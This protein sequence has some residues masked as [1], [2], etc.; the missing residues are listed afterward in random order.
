MEVDQLRYFLRV[1]ERGNFTRAAEELMISQPALSRSIQKLEEELGQ[2]VFERKTRSVALTEAG[3][4]LQS[5][6]QQVLTLLADTKA[7]IS[8]DGQSGQIRVGAIPTIA[9]FFLPDLLRQFSAEFPKA[10]LIVQEDTTDHLLKRCTQG[11][12]DLAII[13]LPIPAKYLEV[14]ELFEEELFLVL[15][16]DHPLVNKPHIRLNDIKSYPFVLLDEAHCL[17]DNIVSFCR[18]RSFHPVA[19]EQTSQLAMVQELVSLSH[20]ISMIPQMARQLDKTD[21]RVYR[22]ISGNRPTRKIAVVWNP[23]RFQSQ[24]LL[25]FRKRL[26]EYSQTQCSLK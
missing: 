19:V 10:S 12:I 9:P 8:D 21:R 4:L 11:E 5:R 6:A 26:H 7:E 2:P 1:A 14:E 17:S 15:P 24:L 25:E 3:K 16:P 20:G 18:Q 13:A 23:Y 22:S